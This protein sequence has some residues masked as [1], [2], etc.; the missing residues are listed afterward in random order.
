MYFAE[1][2]INIAKRLKEL[3]YDVIL[4]PT[5]EKYGKTAKELTSNYTELLKLKQILARYHFDKIKE[6]DAILVVNKEKNG[7]KGYIGGAT[8]SEIAFA[9]YHKKKI[10]LIN[11]IPENLPYTDELKSFEPIILDNIEQIKNFI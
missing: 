8:F 11:P 1:E 5:L 6:S 7:I 4:P 3:G 2:M 9:F 10:F